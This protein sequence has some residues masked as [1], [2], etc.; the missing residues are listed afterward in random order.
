MIVHSYYYGPSSNGDFDLQTT[1]GLA[2][3]VNEDLIRELY[4]M[5]GNP[6]KRIRFNKLYH[7][8]A[9][10]VIGI[11]RI[12]PAQAQDKR[13]TLINKTFFVRLEEVVQDLS[14]T[15]DLFFNVEDVKPIELT[16]TT[17]TPAPR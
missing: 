12:D 10:S 7:T 4:S 6:K 11:T 8:A 1:R 3:V 9:G 14:K 13:P 15:L 5:D 2:R 16:V 17:N